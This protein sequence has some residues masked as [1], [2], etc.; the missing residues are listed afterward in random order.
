[1]EVQARGMGNTEVLNESAETG[2]LS[3]GEVEMMYKPGAK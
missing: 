1:M 2:T 3:E